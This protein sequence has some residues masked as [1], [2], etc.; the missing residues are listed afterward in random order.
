MEAQSSILTEQELALLMSRIT[1]KIERL[2]FALK[3]GTLVHASVAKLPIAEVTDEGYDSIHDEVETVCP[4]RLYDYQAFNAY[5]D[6]LNY[7]YKK[8]G[9]SHKAARRLVGIVH[10]TG[11]EDWEQDCTSLI[12]EINNLKD[13]FSREL[14]KTFS[15]SYKRQEF[16]R[17]TNTGVIPK[18]VTRHISLAGNDIENVTFSWLAQGY[19]LEQ[20]DHKRATTIAKARCEKKVEN[21]EALSFESLMSNDEVK[22][23]PYV[24][25]GVI[26]IRPSKLNPRYKCSYPDPD[27]G[28]KIK[29][30]L[31]CRAS[32]PILILKPAPLKRYHELGDYH[33]KQSL[34][35]VKG[36]K[37]VQRVPIIEEYGFYAP[38]QNDA[39]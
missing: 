34:A 14:S 3:Q 10:M 36:T 28:G 38:A 12:E 39:G 4:E 9:L 15:T 21:N 16:Y 20:I 37:R 11:T 5:L 29:Q 24:N 27:D 19:Q 6:S 31:P 25:K 35:K 8:H 32:L 30:G 23:A 26:W 22:L 17:A 1:N 2:R 7:Q 33:G 18:T 13:T